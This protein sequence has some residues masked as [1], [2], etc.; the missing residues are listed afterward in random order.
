[1]IK[2]TEQQSEAMMKVWNAYLEGGDKYT[3]PVTGFTHKEMDQH[4]L[5]IIPDLRKLLDRYLNGSVTVE[6]FKLKIDEVNKANLLWGFNGANGQAF[7]NS[8]VKSCATAKLHE[9]LN[10]LFKG[11]LPA[12]VTPD[13]AVNN[14]RTFSSF[15]L[16]LSSASADRENAPKVVSIP[17][18]L[19][20]FWQI[21]KPEIWPIYYTAM[22]K[23]LQEQ[24]IWSPSE[25]IAQ[26]YAD[27]TEL[28]NHL[29]DLIDTWTGKEV[30]L[31]DIEHAFWNSAILKT[32]PPVVQEQAPEPEP[33]EEKAVQ[34]VVK[35]M[36]VSTPA[37][38]RAVRKPPQAPTGQFLSESYIPP[39]VAILP[40]LASHETQA[41][42]LCVQAG[43]TIEKV[44]EERL[45]ILFKMLGYDTETPGQGRGRIPAGVATCKEHHYAIIYDAEIRQQGYS[46]GEI[47]S[48]LSEYILKIGDRLRKQGYRMIYFMVISSTFND[49]YDGETRAF[50][51]ETGVNE[52]ILAE[53]GALL[54]LLENKLRDPQISLG[55]RHIQKILAASGL[56]TTGSVSDHFGS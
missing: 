37:T 39:V 19:S 2:L 11:A 38:V 24:G 4:R 13:F 6:E 32:S 14:I 49:E 31:W 21:Q 28:S 26:N 30:K 44:F 3:Y 17:Y 18:F 10:Y 25:D 5:E 43:K 8:I 51:L 55:P 36:R 23:E 7:L 15:L 1:M 52:V 35:P 29:L 47:E 50:K 46:M 9:E 40:A 53:V 22:V 41:A 42:A 16:T 12:P 56:L 33:V 54:L 27:F 45:A 48:A 20:Y 34:P